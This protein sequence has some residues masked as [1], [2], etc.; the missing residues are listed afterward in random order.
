VAAA[1][2]EALLTGGISEPRDNRQGVSVCT[3]SVTVDVR[4]GKA[5]EVLQ[6][7]LLKAQDVST[8]VE[9]PF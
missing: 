7:L 3:V 9:M 6:E 1:Y 2:A 5:F 4:A 8:R